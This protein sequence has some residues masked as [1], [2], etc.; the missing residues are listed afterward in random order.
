MQEGEG[1]QAGRQWRL[2]NMAHLGFLTFVRNCS[3][4]IF[5]I[6]LTKHFS[7][8]FLVSSL[9][10]MLDSVCVCVS[11]ATPPIQCSILLAHLPPASQH[12]SPH[13][14]PGSVLFSTAFQSGI[15][16]PSTACTAGV[17]ERP[18][19]LQQLL[20]RSKAGPQAAGSDCAE[21][22]FVPW[23]L[24]SVHSCVFR[25][26]CTGWPARE[27]VSIH[28]EIKVLNS[29]EVLQHIP[30]EVIQSE[31]WLCIGGAPWE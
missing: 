13:A 12:S 14:F 22:G 6:C 27:A 21:R 4:N 15:S 28:L 24:L 16:C 25:V 23:L 8:P 30:S 7:T 20:A 5:F 18:C 10:I 29:S 19:C 2:R 26:T 17:Q 9:S 31:T 11:H 1:G 3:L